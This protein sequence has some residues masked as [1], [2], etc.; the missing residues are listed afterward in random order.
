MKRA[1][2]LRGGW[3]GAASLGEALGL[4]SRWRSLR[5]AC[6]SPARLLLI[7]E[8][9]Q[10]ELAERVERERRAVLEAVE[11]GA[12]V[13][14]LEEGSSVEIWRQ[15]EMEL[16]SVKML[17]AR[18]QLRKRPRIKQILHVWWETAHRTV[19][20]QL[21]V[22]TA[23]ESLPPADV[24]KKLDEHAHAC[25]L[26][27][28]FR[29]LMDT[30]DQR[31]A[32]QSIAE[33]WAHDCGGEAL[34]SHERFCDAIF[35]VRR[36]A[37]IRIQRTRSVCPAPV[38]VAHA[39]ATRAHRP[40]LCPRRPS[41][42]AR[43]AGRAR[44]HGPDACH[45]ASAS[46]IADVWTAG[47]SEDEYASF[48]WKLLRWVSTQAAEADIYVWKAVA[49]VGRMED[50]GAQ[51]VSE[52]SKEGAASRKA[53][54]A[55]ARKR[56]AAGA[57][58][59]TPPD[60]P[61]RYMD[62]SGWV[63]RQRQLR[64]DGD[65]SDDGGDGCELAECPRASR[66]RKARHRRY[67]ATSIQCAQRCK[68]AR[69]TIRTRRRAVHTIQSA[70][71]GRRAR[72]V[73]Q[74]RRAAILVIQEHV[75]R[76]QSMRVRA[77]ALLLQEHTRGTQGGV[78]AV[79]LQRAFGQRQ[80]E[81]ERELSELQGRVAADVALQRELREAMQ[82]QW[83]EQMDHSATLLR[84][85]RGGRGGVGDSDRTAVYHL[86]A[87]QL[88]P[89][90]RRPQPSCNASLTRVA[91]LPVQQYRMESAIPASVSC[92]IL[93]GARQHAAHS[94]LDRERLPMQL[95]PLRANASERAPPHALPEGRP[96]GRM[97][98]AA[99]TERL[100][101]D[102]GSRL[103]ASDLGV[104]LIESGPAPLPS[105]EL[106][107]LFA[108]HQGRLRTELAD[109]ERLMVTVEDAL[110]SNAQ[111]RLCDTGG[112]GQR[113]RVRVEALGRQRTLGAPTSGAKPM[114]KPKGPRLGPHRSVDRAGGAT[115][116]P[117]GW[118]Q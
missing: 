107:R 47:V 30:F 19:A 81:G 28:V 94:Y 62:T 45:G 56:R 104:Q 116:P 115:R 33:D 14:E 42:D 109:A 21:L 83:E 38:A 70:E 110:R 31:D 44:V 102:A 12:A 17:E 58:A 7:R 57:K 99:P 50:E 5:I 1:G 22:D 117:A 100:E 39:V 118:L 74:R 95:P 66:M 18:L 4:M 92:P 9:A 51:R 2:S 93:V 54:K 114:A 113:T 63:A 79:Q 98:A 52:S 87:T 72:R 59:A 71:R 69:G 20:A 46:Q 76:Q 60:A 82:R 26:L 35:E 29:A 75:R 91:S 106:D 108:R 40:R 16:S 49:D 11:A 85:G 37:A 43:R 77:A 32:A 90:R 96:D 61:A 55:R 67:A 89:V 80:A 101:G 97:R 103:R 112:A 3:R 8:R 27:P 10:R 23:P 68:V 64:G 41:V 15:G 25:C 84:R 48:L 13:T 73:A 34:L 78:R 105:E 86:D 6:G 65:G 36:C 53:S 88:P 111:R 24:H